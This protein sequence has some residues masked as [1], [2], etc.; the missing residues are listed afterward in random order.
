ML[1][2][3]LFFEKTNKEIILLY[4]PLHNLIR[5][6][7]SADNHMCFL[8]GLISL[9]LCRFEFRHTSFLLRI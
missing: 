1:N 7:S 8:A 9:P 2:R 5:V 4:A 3:V 6:L